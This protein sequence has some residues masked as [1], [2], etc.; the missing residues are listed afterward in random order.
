MKSGKIAGWLALIIFE[1]FFC[2]AMFRVDKNDIVSLMSLQGGI[3]F[4]IWGGV[5]SK[6]FVDMKIQHNKGTK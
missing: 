2:V 1:I 4:T 5:A 6:N 3:V